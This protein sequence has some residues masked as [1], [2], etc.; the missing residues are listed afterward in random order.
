MQRS[1]CLIVCGFLFT[2]CFGQETLLRR[3]YLGVRMENTSQGVLIAEVFNKSTASNLG[4]KQGDIITRLNGKPVSA[5]DDILA[6]LRESTAGSPVSV[7]FVRDN[8]RQHTTGRIGAFPKEQHEGLKVHYDFVETTGSK[9]RTITTSPKN[10]GVLPAI[11]YV[12]GIGCGSID[13]P[14]NPD[15]TQTALVKQLTNAGFIVMRVD[16]SGMGDSRGIPCEELDFMTELEGYQAA[17]DKLISLPESDED[18][19][20][21][22]GHS[23]GGVWAP[24]IAKDKKVRAIAA[25]GTIGSKFVDYL[26]ASRLYVAKAQGLSDSDAA[27]VVAQY[28]KCYAHFEANGYDPALTRQ[29]YP[30]CNDELAVLGIRSEA[31]FKQLFDLDITSLWNDFDG[32]VLA[33]WGDG[34]FVSLEKDHQSI[35]ERIN[36]RGQR[37]ASYLEINGADHAMANVN[38]QPSGSYHTEVGEAFIR[39]T[40]GEVVSSQSNEIQFPN[41]PTVKQLLKMDN[42]ENAYPRFGS[43]NSIIFQSNRDGN[44]Q[45]YTMNLDGENQKNLSNNKFNDNFVSV[46]ADGRKIAFVSDRDGN[47]EIYIMDANGGN[48]VRLTSHPGRDIHPYFSPDGKEIYFNS[49]RAGGNFEQYVIDISGKNLRRLTSGSDEVTCGRLSPDA[50]SIVLLCGMMRTMNDEILAMDPD[51]KNIRNLTKSRAAEGWPVWSH[52]G[53]K[54]F[55][56]STRTGDTFRIYVM[57]EDGSNVQ[58][59]TEVS[60]PFMDARPEISGDGKLMVFNRQTRGRDGRNTIAI[61]LKKLG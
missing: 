37:K 3:P 13:N 33:I 31:F 44:W 60:P 28:A 57:D 8:K 41:D 4:L 12:Q 15:N 56:A 10:D 43:N 46:S 30:D 22:F 54:I 17:L 14:L 32:D 21:I 47:E 2:N 23:M 55:F 40:K 16:K 58:Q 18:H 42:V 20:Y 9:L 49:T 6:S 59:I 7:S 1:I 34:D 45:I 38:R 19:I 48:V 61:Y 11:L 36:A 5:I 52:D 26:V 50:K 25:Y 27:N 29:K 24:M 39:W 35:V 51:G 53:K